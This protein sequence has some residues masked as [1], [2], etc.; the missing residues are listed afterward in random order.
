LCTIREPWRI[1]AHIN[2]V[3]VGGHE[4]ERW[5]AVREESREHCCVRAVSTYWYGVGSCGMWYPLVAQ[6]VNAQNPR[7]ERVAVHV[8][9]L[10]PAQKPG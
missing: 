10:D 5:Y 2:V 6:S 7:C 1:K 4:C 3:V 9:R 8:S